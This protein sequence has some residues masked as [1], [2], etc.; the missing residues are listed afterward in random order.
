MKKLE[1]LLQEMVVR[2]FGENAWLLILQQSLAGCA[3]DQQI[4][5]YG[6]RR[7]SALGL[8]VSGVRGDQM[9]SFGSRLLDAAAGLMGTTVPGVLEDLGGYDTREEL[10]HTH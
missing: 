4:E 8:M 3:F 7:V 10:Q 2:R 9:L 6:A 1:I 5:S